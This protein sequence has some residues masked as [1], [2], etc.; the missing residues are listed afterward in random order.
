MSVQSEIVPETAALPA[1]MP[2]DRPQSRRRSRRAA[3]VDRGQRDR[4]TKRA[5]ARALT[6]R[7]E[8]KRLDAPADAPGELTTSQIRQAQWVQHFKAGGTV[9]RKGRP[10]SPEETRHAKWDPYYVPPESVE[11]YFR[12]DPFKLGVQ[13]VTFRPEL[14]TDDEVAGWR[15]KARDLGLLSVEQ[16][17]DVREALAELGDSYSSALLRELTTAA[18]HDDPL[19]PIIDAEMERRALRTEALVAEIGDQIDG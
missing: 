12:S 16:L 6:P 2:L 9:D 11:R 1:Y 8:R 7:A 13:A 19:E 17:A 18:L 14:C 3:V 5:M 10:C 4:V 15:A